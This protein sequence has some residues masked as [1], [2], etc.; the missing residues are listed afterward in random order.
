MTDERLRQLQRAAA[1]GDPDARAALE[2]ELVRAHQDPARLAE[3]DR[4]LAVAVEGAWLRC[5]YRRPSGKWAGG[6]LILRV[7]VG[8]PACS[9]ESWR[10]RSDNGKWSGVDARHLVT[11]PRDWR[12]TVEAAG[13]AVGEGGLV[14]SAEPEDEGRWA[15][16]RAAPGR[17][18][19]L[20]AE[21]GE[22]LRAEGG[23]L[24][25]RRAVRGRR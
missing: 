25:W 10:V 18:F 16:T 6:N 3:L 7:T 1:T 11:V 24:R 8:E 9:G 21:A 13:L 2:R 23:E 5:A 17:G 20:R 22:I 15:A 4:R 12:R 19:S 14:L